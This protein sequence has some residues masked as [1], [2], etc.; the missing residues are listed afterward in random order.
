MSAEEKNKELC[1]RII[2]ILKICGYPVA[3]KLLK[4][5]IDVRKAR[6]R[7][8]CQLISQT[9]YIGRRMLITKDE[10]SCY[11]APTILGFRELPKEAW[12]RYIGWQFFDEEA[13]KK[14]FV[15]VPKFELGAYSALYLGPLERFEMEPDGVIFY[16]NASQA[17]LVVA[18][19]VHKKG[20]ALNFSASGVG[21]CAN[22][23]VTPKKEKLPSISIPGNAYRLLALPS[24]TDL[25]ISIPYDILNE[26]ISNMFFMRARGGSR[27]PFAWQHIDW[28]MQPPIS[29]LL[30]DDGEAVWL[31][32]S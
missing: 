24:D 23:I 13:V 30:K 20:G 16:G 29:E 27:Y 31:K 22:A 5:E 7:T 4:E 28:E 32:K 10:I 9:Y 11:L 6:K 12:K 19:Y 21:V 1:K 2:E 17:L 8:L 14:T 15:T 18:A 25:I 3:F 26:L